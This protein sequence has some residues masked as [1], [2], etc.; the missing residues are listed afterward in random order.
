M[1]IQALETLENQ[2]WALLV[3]LNKCV[4]F[5]CVG[6]KAIFRS[7]VRKK[8]LIHARTKAYIRFL[9][10]QNKGSKSDD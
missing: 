7:S 5:E 8:K 4:D 2:A 10:R 9:R 6:W 1:N 3:K